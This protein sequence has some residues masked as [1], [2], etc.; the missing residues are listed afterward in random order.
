[1]TDRRRNTRLHPSV[2]RDLLMIAVITL[3]LAVVLL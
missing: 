3:L 2:K 1:M